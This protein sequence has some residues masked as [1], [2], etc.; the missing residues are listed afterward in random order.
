MRRLHKNKI[1]VAIARELEKGGMSLKAIS[2][3]MADVR[4]N[5]RAVYSR[6]KDQYRLYLIIGNTNKNL[7]LGRSE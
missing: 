3:V 5:V 4:A 2:K 6:L 7:P 1:K